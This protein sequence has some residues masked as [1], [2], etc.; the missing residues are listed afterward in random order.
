[1]D[2]RQLA[3]VVAV[4]DEGSV[5]GAAAALGLSQPTL[6]QTIRG[7]EAELGVALFHRVGRTLRPTAAGEALLG[8]ARQALRDVTTARAAVA[9]V[10][11]TAAGRLDIVTLP[12]LAVHPV[13]GLVGSFRRAHPG[14][15]VRLAEPEDA[16]AVAERV[17]HGE[18]E[19]GFADLADL[20][21]AGQ[22]GGV[23]A[24]ELEVQE[25]VALLPG[26]E[27][28]PEGR[29]PLKL[30]DLAARPLITTP[31][32]TS[33]RR[34]VDEAFRAAGLTM[35]VG[36]ESDHREAIGP[37][38]RAGAGAAVLPRALAEQVAGAGVVLR[39]LTP[40]IRRRVGM[41]HRDGPLSPAAAAFVALATGDRVPA[42]RP[43][44]RR[45]RS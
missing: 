25:Y 42:H 20:G 38:V 17:R 4:V 11:G 37:L 2:I 26:E 39:E 13:A 14:V 28:P 33:T 6:S 45:R 8:P 35:I 10:A 12:T 24:H 7:L 29:H 5:T 44:A 21:S 43:P 41:L 22:G 30:A 40:P 32:G 16:H 18:A 15:A 36:V 27:A 23:V 9:A 34:Q 3:A 1:M 31:P 19:V